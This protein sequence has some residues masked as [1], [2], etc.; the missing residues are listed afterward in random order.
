M[1]PHESLAV[2]F[3][4]K[5][6]PEPMSGCWLWTA[7][8]NNRGYGVLGDGGHAIVLA[9]RTSWL[10]HR[11]EIPSGLWVLHRCDNRQCVN[12]GHLYLGDVIDNARDHMNR[13]DPY[14]FKLRRHITPE[15]E[16]RRIANMPRGAAHHRAAAKITPDIAMA[17]FKGKGVQRAIADQYGVSQQTVSL[18][19]K[20]RRWGYLHADA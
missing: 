8:V 17:I 3:D 2:R 19:K 7:A 14:C 15:V 18:I 12:P 5:H 4:R 6:E 20:R 10:L 16:A 1:P 11:G 9:H 13:G